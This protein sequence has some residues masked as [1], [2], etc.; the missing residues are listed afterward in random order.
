MKLLAGET[1]L[2][3]APGSV[4]FHNR[5][6]KKEGNFQ[7]FN[8]MPCS[9]YRRVHKQQH[10][11][12]SSQASPFSAAKSTVASLRSMSDC[13]RCRS[14]FG[15]NRCVTSAP[16]EATSAWR[17]TMELMPRA[18]QAE[19]VKACVCQ[20]CIAQTSRGDESLQHSWWSLSGAT[21]RARLRG[22]WAKTSEQTACVDFFLSWAQFLWW[23]MKTHMKRRHIS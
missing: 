14:A 18:L 16:K 3:C 5:P 7:P 4:L 1:R 13:T 19:G 2:L 22:H 21:D 11:D 10:R 9:S 17:A 23:H 20:R 12:F 15:P 6:T 8:E